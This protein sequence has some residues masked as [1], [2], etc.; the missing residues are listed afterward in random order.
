MK[1]ELIPDISLDNS[2]LE[3]IVSPNLDQEQ[4]QAVQQK[5]GKILVSEIGRAHV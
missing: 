5:Q 1:T 2:G 3:K 4:D